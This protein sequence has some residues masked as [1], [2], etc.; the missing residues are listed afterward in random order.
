MGLFDRFRSTPLT[1]STTRRSVRD[2]PGP[3]TA[4]EAWALA[5]PAARALDPTA[6]LTLLTSG[7]DLGPDGR[8]FTWEF[9]FDLLR[10]KAYVLITIE[11]SGEGE[12]IDDD[13]VVLVQRVRPV[14][15]SE[16][17]RRPALPER[18]RD[19]PEVVAEFASRGV[20]FVAGPTD[21]K[22][23]GRVVATGESVW[24]TYDWDDEQTA[25][26]GAGAS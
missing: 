2:E 25:A 11:P 17:G 22:L 1:L 23:E 6:Q 13:P 12:D 5:E 21:M 3:L 14:D 26:F 19:S 10:R 18:F 20:D 16:L 9:G 4:H 8:S 24:V 7:L 15:G